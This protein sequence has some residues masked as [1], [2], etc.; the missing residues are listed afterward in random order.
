M[1][2]TPSN[3]HRHR[4]ADSSQGNHQTDTSGLKF[5]SGLCWVPNSPEALAELSRALERYHDSKERS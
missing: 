5:L 3:R 1:R 4:P 2:V